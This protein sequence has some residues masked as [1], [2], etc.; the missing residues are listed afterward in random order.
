MVRRRMQG[1]KADELPESLLGT[2]RLS[3]ARPTPECPGTSTAVMHE[4]RGRVPLGTAV[5]ALPYFGEPRPAHHPAR[6]ACLP[7]GFLSHG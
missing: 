7:H 1:N 3:Q 4:I 5:N 2:M 6:H